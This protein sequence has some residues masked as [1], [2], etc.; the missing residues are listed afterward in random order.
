M[1]GE[2]L[3]K[4]M[5]SIVVPNTGP[6][7]LTFNMRLYTSAILG[8]GDFFLASRGYWQSCFSYIYNKSIRLGGFG[9][10]KCITFHCSLRFRRPGP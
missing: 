1:R 9:F 2:K 8:N 10:D 5:R 7:L 3:R 4:L 6:C